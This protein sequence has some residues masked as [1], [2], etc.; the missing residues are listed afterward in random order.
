MVERNNLDGHGLSFRR[1]RNPRVRA[2]LAASSFVCYKRPAVNSTA[3]SRET[4]RLNREK[5]R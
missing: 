1:T 2:A 3:T 5:L 4:T